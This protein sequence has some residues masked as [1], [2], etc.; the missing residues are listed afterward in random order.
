MAIN[1]P[2]IVTN[3]SNIPDDI[4]SVSNQSIFDIATQLYGS[5]EF[6]IKVILDNNRY[7]LDEELVPRT[8]IAYNIQQTQSPYY[9]RTNNQKIANWV[10][11]IMETIELRE[12][13]GLEL[14]EDLGN[15]LRQ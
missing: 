10:E 13:L 2:R 8:K 9:L 4:M 3:K 12:D 7:G 14:R 15:E 5:P 6:A 1:Y 11:P